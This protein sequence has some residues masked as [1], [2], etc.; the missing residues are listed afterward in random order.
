MIGTVISHYSVQEKLGEGGMGVVYRAIDTHLERSVALKFLP[1]DYVQDPVLRDRFLREARAASALNHPNICTIYEAGED[2]GT[3]FIA[4]EFL[5]GVTLKEVVREGPAEQEKLLAIALDVIDALAAAHAAGVVHRDIKPANIFLTNSGRAKI[6]D[7]GLAKRMGPK[8]IG[9]RLPDSETFASSSDESQL[10]SGLGAL[11]TAAYMSPEQALGTSLDQ[12]TDLFSLGIV[13]Y[14]LATGRAPFRGDTTGKL[15]LSILQETPD[16]PRALNPGIPEDLQLIIAKCLEKDRGLR[17]QQAAEV[18]ADLHRL[19]L[20][21]G[22]N[23]LASI[24]AADRNSETGVSEVQRRPSGSSWPVRA[25]PAG[26]AFLP[27]KPAAKSQRRGWKVASALGAL[28]IVFA[29]AAAF[30]LHHRAGALPP[31]SSIVIA[32][33]ANTTGDPVFDNTLK[34]ALSVALTQSPFVNVLSDNRVAQTLKLMTL[35]ATARL[36]PE[37]ARELCRRANA[38]AYIAGSIDSLGKEYVIGLKALNCQ[39]DEP[40][41]EEQ[42]TANV[43]EQVLNTLGDAAAKLRGKLGESLAT[44]EKF[45]V[46]MAQATTS[47]LEALQ[48][49]SIGIR[50][51]VPRTALP[52]LERAVQIDPNFAQAY[53]SIG[54]VYFALAELEEARKYDTKAFELRDHANER[55][56]LAIT[57]TYYRSVTGELDK[58]AQIYREWIADYSWNA[59]AYGSLGIIYALQGD[60]QAAVDTTRQQLQMLPDNKGPYTNLAYYLMALQRSEEAREIIRQ[61]QARRLDSFIQHNALYNMAF[62]AGDSRGMAE[63]QEW[64]ATN[65]AVENAG[66]SLASD[67]EAY[68]G[69]L[70]AARDLTKRAA[71]SAVRAD[72]KENAAIWWENAS[73]R[74]AAFGNFK[75]ARDDAEAGVKL[76]PESQGVQLEAALAYAMAGN[77][78]RAEEMAENL[79]D[80]HPLDTQVQSL[81]LPAIRAQLALN[82]GNSGEGIDQLS[83]ALP[84]IEYGEALFIHQ[85]T[86]LYPTYIRGQAYL[87]AGKGE[88]AAAEFQKILDHNGMVST[89]WTGALARLGVARANALEA[90]SAQGT[91]ADAARVRS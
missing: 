72:S 70:Q 20:V 34:T 81:W 56:K 79:N 84:P 32:D 3:V 12:R 90:R 48:A 22:A 35:P 19:Q 49:Y 24:T 41:G 13:L 45:D 71:D 68:G 66:L 14:E 75:R 1:E 51:G 82:R 60:Y 18:R 91:D 59:P 15:F 86:C 65:P 36:T 9:R 80:R 25:Q 50:T 55:E 10:T 39:T 87:A 23:E 16:E 31:Q 58:A 69:R 27:D 29:L 17:Y 62:L 88:D 63:Q 67:A 53:A 89:C 74:E 6:L 61:A 73:L 8:R 26:S 5:D 83:G 4:M 52:Y 37:V 11:G 28:V 57:A 77:A 42:A 85:I 33:F 47:S 40:L 76:Y 78:Q 21:S 7:F 2:N 46:P 38:Q 43:K 54:S 30:R 64:F 44:V